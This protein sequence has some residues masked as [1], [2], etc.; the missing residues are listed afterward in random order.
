MPAAGKVPVNTSP[1]PRD[2]IRGHTIAWS[3]WQGYAAALFKIFDNDLG[4]VAHRQYIMFGNEL[5]APVLKIITD[6]E[7]RLNDLM[8]LLQDPEIER[9]N[10]ELYRSFQLILAGQTPRDLAYQEKVLDQ[11]LA[12]TGGWKVAMFED[13]FME[14]WSNLY[15]IKLGYKNFNYVL[16]GGFFDS[17][18]GGG[19]PD[20]MTSGFMEVMRD[21]YNKFG[22]PGGIVDHGGDAGMG[23]MGGM[24]GGGYPGFE[25]FVLYD[26]GDAESVR[27]ARACSGDAAHA[28][29]ERVAPLGGGGNITG[30]AP[31]FTK[32]ERRQ[33]VLKGLPHPQIMRYQRQIWEMLDPNQV[34]DGWYAHLTEEEID[35]ALSSNGGGAIPGI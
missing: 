35:N 18:L 16:A 12:D 22:R 23:G 9:L 29:G 34:G 17:T 3:D 20:V 32:D 25:N 13:P 24:G 31:F 27:V 6:P 11:I 1:L 2:V 28:A 19:T 7:K 30:P 21:Q 33:T 8:P 26:P 4:Y 10:D 14:D 15:M 5:Q